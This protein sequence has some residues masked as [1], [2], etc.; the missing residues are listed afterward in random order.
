MK[1][2]RDLRILL[3]SVLLLVV[4]GV[5]PAGAED[6]NRAVNWLSYRE[7]MATAE[8]EDLPILLHFTGS[9]SSICRKMRRETYGDRH[10]VPFLNEKFV[11]AMIDI[12][13]LPSLARKYQVKD[14]RA[15]WFLDATGKPLSRI[16][17]EVGPEKMLRVGQ[18]ISE[19]I[20][21]HTNYDTWLKKRPSR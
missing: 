10:V 17:G 5:L 7:A 16:D 15:V 9:Y 19:K 11:V 20:Y 14:V 4:V 21:E 12:E 8:R 6:E 2:H 18:Y 13:K 1:L 3:L